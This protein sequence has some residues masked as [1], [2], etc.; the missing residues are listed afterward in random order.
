MR[1]AAI[2]CFGILR[3]NKWIVEEPHDEFHPE[4]VTYAGM[5]GTQNASR[6][7]SAANAASGERRERDPAAEDAAF[8]SSRMR[9]VERKQRVAGSAGL[10]EGGRSLGRLRQVDPVDE[11]RGRMLPVADPEVDAVHFGKME[12]SLGGRT[13]GRVEFHTEMVSARRE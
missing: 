1:I 10:A 4:H 2:D 5:G 9:A 8:V 13:V 3:V 11:N 6:E 12:R 7:D